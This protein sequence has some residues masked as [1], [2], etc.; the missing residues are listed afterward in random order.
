MLKYV[1]G[2]GFSAGLSKYVKPKVMPPSVKAFDGVAGEIDRHNASVV[3]LSDKFESASGKEREALGRQLHRALLDELVAT[4][5]FDSML[6]AALRDLRQLLGETRRTMGDRKSR[7]AEIEKR[8]ERARTP[9]DAPYERAR[10]IAERDR[11]RRALGRLARDVAER[12]RALAVLRGLQRDNCAEEA[13]DD[14]CVG[15][16][17]QI[18]TIMREDLPAAH[19]RLARDRRLMAR[20]GIEGGDAEAKKAME[21]L[22]ARKDAL[23]K[24]HEICRR[25]NAK[26][27][28]IIGLWRID[29]SGSNHPGKTWG[30]G[31]LHM[32]LRQEGDRITG[33]YEADRRRGPSTINGTLKG[34]T[35]TGRFTWRGTGPNG[36]RSE[37]SGGF[38]WKFNASGDFFLGTWSAGVGEGD[39]TGW[40][41]G[42]RPRLATPR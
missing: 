23:A 39:W 41:P 34:D 29:G 9:G 15:Y 38:T 36:E 21:R 1:I 32:V 31:R 35:L 2:Q 26:T 7:V 27:S 18:D 20:T 30:G 14:P 25:R 33:T 37:V 4:M 40:R 10:V 22:L 5:R 42:T 13:E 12:R 28:S 19:A 8:L 17:D 3:K 16:A 24:A 6:P 11:I